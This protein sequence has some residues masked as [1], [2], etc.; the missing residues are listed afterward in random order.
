[1]SEEN[2]DAPTAEEAEEVAETQE[3]TPKD[4]DGDEVEKDL[5]KLS[6][7]EEETK[8]DG[9]GEE[10]EIGEKLSSS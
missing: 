8:K 2:V 5:E 7:E 1:M 9:D 4:A 6:V 3:D 10:E